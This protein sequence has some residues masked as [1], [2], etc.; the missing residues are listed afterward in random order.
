MVE[1]WK[2]GKLGIKAEKVFLLKKIEYH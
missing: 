2:N 1:Y